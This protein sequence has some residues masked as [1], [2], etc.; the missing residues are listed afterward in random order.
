M[1][2]IEKINNNFEEIQK[3]IASMAQA[4]LLLQTTNKV[5]LNEMESL[6]Q[7]NNILVK[8]I[9]VLEK[10]TKKF[11]DKFKF[12]KFKPKSILDEIQKEPQPVV[13]FTLN[14]D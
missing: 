6:K 10:R 11:S 14:D 1:E 5:L 7:K 9:D 12:G 4:I 2:N 3:N 8:H 13:K